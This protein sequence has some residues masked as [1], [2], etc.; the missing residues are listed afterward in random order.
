MENIFCLL[1]GGKGFVPVHCASWCFSSVPEFDQLVGRRFKSHQGAVFSPDRYPGSP[2]SFRGGGHQGLGRNLLSSPTQ[3]EDAVLMVRDPMP[4]DPHQEPEP[5]TWVRTEGKVGYSIPLP[6]MMNGYGTTGFHAL[7]K[8][9]ILWAVGDSVRKR[10]K[11]FCRARSLEVRN[12]TIS[13]YERRP[14]PLPFQLPLPRGEHEAHA[15]SVGFRL[16]LFASEPEI[17]NP[18]Y[19]QWDD[20]DLWVVEPRLP[21]RDQAGRKGND[22][23]KICEDTDGDGKAAKFTVLPR[24][25]TSPFP[26]LCP[27]RVILAHAPDFFFLKDTD[28]DDRAD[29]QEVLFTGFGPGDTHGPSNLRFE[30]DNW[31]YGTVGYSLQWGS[32]RGEA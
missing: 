28:G 7:L 17:V 14:E 31:I 6:G 22:R 13:N 15:S 8:K 5:W 26:Y 30:L 1:K 4:G 9:G 21:E 11:L 24:T 29:L 25:L 32:K 2:G 10:C 18:I 27:G 12:A 19:F 23:I 20:A 16:E 3:S